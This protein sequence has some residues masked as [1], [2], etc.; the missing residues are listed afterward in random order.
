MKAAP[1]QATHF[2]IGLL[3][4]RLM[5][6]VVFF[7]HGSMKLFGWFGGGGLAGGAAFNAR[8]GLPFPLEGALLAGLAEF[9]G[10]LALAAGI[11]VRWAVIPLI[12]IMLVASSTAHRGAFW[13][14]KD[15]MEYTVTLAVFLVA[16]GIMGPGRFTA[17]RLM[18]RRQPPLQDR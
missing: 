11:G 5:L 7:F 10:A 1:S 14:V 15:G 8:L 12:F 3:L 17:A 13:V 4:I 18:R 6:A 2:E 9:F 16:L